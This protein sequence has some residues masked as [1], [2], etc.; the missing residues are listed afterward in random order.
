MG[1]I[2]ACLPVMR[3]L[4]DRLPFGSKTGKRSHQGTAANARLGAI[5]LSGYT[6][7]PVLRHSTETMSI[8]FAHLDEESGFAARSVSAHASK[9][10]AEVLPSVGEG[11]VH[12]QFPSEAYSASP[13]VPKVVM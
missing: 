12:H 9:E 11:V 7:R 13:Q 8:G 1:I 2:C 4:F 10:P 3:P 5:P 6:S